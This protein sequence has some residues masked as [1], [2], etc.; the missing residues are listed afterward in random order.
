[1]KIQR[2]RHELDG[3]KHLR[4]IPHRQSLARRWLVDRGDL[5]VV[6]VRT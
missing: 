1:M 3:R 4:M 6:C 5:L 2:L